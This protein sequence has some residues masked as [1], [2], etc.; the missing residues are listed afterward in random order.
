MQPYFI[1]ATSSSLLHVIYQ[2]TITEN[3]LIN[4][5]TAKTDCEI[6][7]E[8][9]YSVRLNQAIVF[10]SFDSASNQLIV[11]KVEASQQPV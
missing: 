3:V 10:I 8:L 2:K 1:D 7:E 5:P 11:N 6:S 4:L 9:T